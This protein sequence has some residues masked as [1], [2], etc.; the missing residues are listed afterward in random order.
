MNIFEGYKKA[1][2][3]YN[4]NTGTTD[5]KEQV[6]WYIHDLGVSKDYLEWFTTCVIKHKIPLYIVLTTYRDWKKYVIPYFQK[7]NEET[8]NIYNLNHKQAIKVV[9]QCKRYWAKPNPIYDS[10]GVYIGVFNS[11]KDAAMLPINTTWCITK[12]NKR[13]TEFNNSLNKS[14]Y[15]TN[16]KNQ[17]PFRRVIAVVYPDRIEYWDSF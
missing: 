8:P 17:D 11:F 5:G 9:D 13:F 7:N 1:V 4:K 10:N 16:N 14:L 12:T 15:I 2:E 6:S 3:I